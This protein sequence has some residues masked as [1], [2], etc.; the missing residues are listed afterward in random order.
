MTQPAKA[1]FDSFRARVIAHLLLHYQEQ[2]CAR[3]TSRKLE[4]KLNCKERAFFIKAVEFEFAKRTNR[5]QFSQLVMPLR[6][7]RTARPVNWSV[8]RS[9]RSNSLRFPLGL[10]LPSIPPRQ[11]PPPQNGQRSEIAAIVLAAVLKCRNYRHDLAAGTRANRKAGQ[12]SRC[13]I[14]R[15]VHGVEH[16]SGAR[17][18]AL[19][20]MRRKRRRVPKSRTDFE[21]ACRPNLLCRQSRRSRQSESAG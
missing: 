16:Y 21:R 4:G 15:S 7:A 9:K 5:H 19:P 6:S 1:D 13:A 17:R 18:Q 8:F 11:S 14:A 3:I 20:D 10:L 2:I 12:Q